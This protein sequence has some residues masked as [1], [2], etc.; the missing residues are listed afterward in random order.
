MKEGFVTAN[1]LL[2][3]HT[4]VLIKLGGVLPT[5]VGAALILIVVD[6]FTYTVFRWGVVSTQGWSR[7]LYGIGFILVIVLCYLFVI[8]TL[9]RLNRRT[10]RWRISSKWMFS[11]LI[12]VL[13][14]S[15]ASLLVRDGPRPSPISATAYATRRPHILLITADGVDAS[16]TS[17][18]GYHRNTTPHLRDLAHSALVAE[19]AYANTEHTAGSC[20]SIYTGKYPA[21][22]RVFWLPNILRGADSYEHLP[23]LLRSQGYRTV[24]IAVP[25][26]LDPRRLNLRDGFDEV[27]LSTSVHSIYLERISKALS[28]D[29]ALFTDELLNRLADRIRHIFFVEK[30]QNPYL[31][32]TTM[33]ALTV[34][35]ERWEHLRQEIQTT[36]QPL[37]VH[38]HLMVTHG[39]R[40]NPVEQLFSAGQSIARQPLWSVDFYDDSIRDFDRNVGDLVDYLTGVGMLDKTVVIIGSDHGHRMD[41]TLKRLPLIFRFP[42]GQYAGRIR[43]NVQ[44]LDI[45]PT[46]LEYMGMAR[47]SWMR[48]QSLLAGEP[49]QR[50]VFG[51]SEIDP[52]DSDVQGS[53]PSTSVYPR[54]MSRLAD[55]RP[56]KVTANKGSAA[57]GEKPAARF[58][59]YVLATLIHCQ[60][61]YRLDSYNMSWESGTVEGSTAAC[62]PGT[63]I[64][65]KL[66]FRWILNHLTEN[67]FDVSGLGTYG[68]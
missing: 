24:Q 29:K 55:G 47:P 30:M 59:I 5:M 18:Y 10:I 56:T 32:V 67:G 58:G 64:T 16:H 2:N 49:E 1:R 34:D 57:V 25:L 31:L 27:K 7:G 60:N 66:A 52:E 46:V 9:V 33:A 36:T 3:R 37:F 19:N 17:L 20:V 42:N 45:A 44:N 11:V 12:C 40:F 61:W 4:A 21:T 62:K 35:V 13:L 8:N 63:E 43:A 14:L 15:V 51:V 50:P 65:D 68:G 23:G 22:T 53:R 39:R 48:G 28:R 41:K 6:N 54:V 26:F 38:I